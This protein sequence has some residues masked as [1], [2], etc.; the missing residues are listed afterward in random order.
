MLDRDM[1]KLFAR[2]ALERLLEEEGQSNF[3]NLY[4]QLILLL[5]YLLRYR[6][7]DSSC[8][9]PNFPETIQEFE[10][11]I[12]SMTVAMKYFKRKR[13]HRKAMRVQE[14]IEGFEKYLYYKGTGD[15]LTVLTD[16]AG[17]MA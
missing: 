14:I 5:F 8:F 1:A 10:K 13:Q 2:R 17:D 3:Q 16:L 7:T 11:A 9:D 4:F 15:V 6:R 12:E